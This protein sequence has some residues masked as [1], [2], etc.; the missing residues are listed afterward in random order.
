VLN[1]CV[2]VYNLAGKVQLAKQHIYIYIY[3]GV[4]FMGHPECVGF[5]GKRY[6]TITWTSTTAPIFYD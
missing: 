1:I 2:C 3:I 6:F 5:I 4:I